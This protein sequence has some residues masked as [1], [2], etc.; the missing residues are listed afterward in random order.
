MAVT[1]LYSSEG[2]N[3]FF[4]FPLKQLSSIK[5]VYIYMCVWRPPHSTS[6]QHL[7]ASS[8]S[9][10]IVDWQLN[11]Q[12][13]TPHTHFLPPSSSLAARMGFLYRPSKAGEEALPEVADIS[14]WEHFIILFARWD[15]STA[16]FLR[17]PGT[18]K[19]AT[20]TSH[21]RSHSCT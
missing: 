18:L 5:K 3:C 17:A 13:A 6:K 7:R 1:H 14:S 20:V 12:I 4:F 16:V 2:R 15:F 19:E 11:N 9:S 8:T 10:W 21:V